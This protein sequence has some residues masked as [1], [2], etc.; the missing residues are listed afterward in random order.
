MNKLFVYILCMMLISFSV[1]A[2]DEVAVDITLLVVPEKEACKPN[3]YASYMSGTSSKCQQVTIDDVDL[4]KAYEFVHIERNVPPGKISLGDTLFKLLAAYRTT[5]EY[6][7][8]ERKSIVTVFDWGSP[9]TA[10][11]KFTR[12]IFRGQDAPPF[13][14]RTWEGKLENERRWI[15]HQRADAF[16]PAYKVLWIIEKGED[17]WILK[18]SR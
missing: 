7:A 4:W 5:L 3:G 13:P 9:Q 2:N 12:K 1:S 10:E 8:S 17:K 11:I 16:L 18:T 15:H 14:D 6:S